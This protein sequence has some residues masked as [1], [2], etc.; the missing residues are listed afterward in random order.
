MQSKI[1]A[2]VTAVV[3]AAALLQT[4]CVT[5]EVRPLEKINAVQATQQI[6][7]AELLDVGIRIFDPGIPA[8]LAANEEALA[9]KRI[10]P[11][12]RKAE[13]RFLPT[14]L[15]AT[16]ESS[17]Q[18]GAVRVLPESAE[19]VDVLVQG[20]ILEST[21]ARLALEVSVQDSAG[22]RWID[23]KRYESAADL[24]SYKS[25]AALTARDPFQNIYAQIANDMLAARELLT[26]DDRR[27]I[28]RT[29]S[30]ARSDARFCRS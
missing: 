11:E 16:L 9:K 14:N 10:Y 30:G 12:L 22:R 28:R 19:F 13:A 3:V 15:R 25:A 21:G 20:R 2:R 5:S 23:K 29:R 4:G 18:W 1:A 26:A 17:A 24:G 7:Q 8:E 6:P 27:D